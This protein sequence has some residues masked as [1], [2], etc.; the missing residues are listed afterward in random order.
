MRNEDAWV[1]SKYVLRRGQLVASDDSTEVRIGSRLITN[2]VA[3]AYSGAIPQY[4]HGRLLDLGCG[5]APLYGIYRRYVT[6]VVCADWSNTLHGATYLDVVC[7]LSKALPLRTASFDSVLLSDVLEH[8]AEPM[9]LLGEIQ[10]V[11]KGGG[12]L[13]MNVPFYYWVHEAPHDYFRYTEFAL[14]RML[15]RAD[16]RVETLVAIG[17]MPEAV[18]DLLGKWLARAPKG[19]RFASRMLQGSIQLLC[20]TPILRGISERTRTLTPLGYLVV[21]RR[22]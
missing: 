19:G 18:G 13:L 11:L 17:G 7:D 14:Q 15:S 2:L 1:P 12:R 20:R 21:A 9:A 22:A 6:D 5:K 8:I 4:V 10:R 16:L 3:S